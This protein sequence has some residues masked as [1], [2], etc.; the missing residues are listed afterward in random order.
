MAADLNQPSPVALVT[1]AARR[2]GREIA[3]GL[4]EAGWTVAV[5]YH[6]SAAEAE[7]TVVQI[8]TAGGRARAYAAD[9]AREDQVQTLARRVQDELGAYTCLVNNASRFDYDSVA[10]TTRESWDAHMEPNLRAPFVLSQSLYAGL[11]DGADGHI[12]NLLDQRVWNLTPHFLSYTV[13]KAGL[14]ALTQSL[15]LAMAPRVRVN[16]IG[17]GPTLPSPHQSDEQFAAYAARQPLQRPASPEEIRRAVLFI[18]SS[19]SLTGQMLALDGGQHLNWAPGKAAP[20][21]Q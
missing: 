1:G 11:P 21:D 7:E 4:A 9:L 2:I 8:K 13:S 16:G 14:W 10:S 6:S 15:A 5:H 19:P 3:L 17:P 12:V 20:L 18:L